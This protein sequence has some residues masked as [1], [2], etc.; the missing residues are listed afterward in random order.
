MFNLSG[1]GLGKWRWKRLKDRWFETPC[2]GPDFQVELA[3]ITKAFYKASQD[4]GGVLYIIHPGE[5]T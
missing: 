1:F 4:P 5:L 2:L 3:E